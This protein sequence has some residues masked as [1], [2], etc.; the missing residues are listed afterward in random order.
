MYHISFYC[1]YIYFYIRLSIHLFIHSTLETYLHDIRRNE[2]FP[3]FLNI[4]ET[5]FFESSIKY[6]I[7]INFL[8]T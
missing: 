1:Y 7:V 4:A 3:M 2:N 5:L 8:Q 6:N